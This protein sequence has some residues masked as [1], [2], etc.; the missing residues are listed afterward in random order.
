MKS[1]K[2]L[3][4]LFMLA[5]SLFTTS[6]VHSSPASSNYIFH[7]NG[8]IAWNFDVYSPFFHNNVV[9]AWEGIK[10]P[11]NRNFSYDTGKVAWKGFTNKE[12][13]FSY[14][15]CTV[16]HRN[17]SKLWQGAANKETSFSYDPCT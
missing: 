9:V 4:I 6:F 17:G 1:L 5:F 11:Y 15:P 3:S 16:Y 10:N 2:Q 8:V 12:T 7:S 14:D 13:S